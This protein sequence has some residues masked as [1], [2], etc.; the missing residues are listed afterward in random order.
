MMLLIWMNTEVTNSPY[1]HLYLLIGVVKHKTQ[2]DAR[3]LPDDVDGVT[4]SRDCF[5]T[6]P[7]RAVPLIRLEAPV[8]NMHCNVLTRNVPHRLLSSPRAH[9]GEVVPCPFITAPTLFPTDARSQRESNMKG[10]KERGKRPLGK[11]SDIPRGSGS[12]PWKENSMTQ[13]LMS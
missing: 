10:N 6:F 3:S 9:F 13:R 2:W 7:A 5:S 1:L 11:R 12:G 4:T 8:S